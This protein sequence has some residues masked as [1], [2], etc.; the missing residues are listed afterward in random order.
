MLNDKMPNYCH[1]TLVQSMDELF[2][3]SYMYQSCHR[4]SERLVEH[5]RTDVFY[6]KPETVHPSEG[7][8][9]WLLLKVKK[10]KEEETLPSS[11]E[12]SNYLLASQ[13]VDMSQ[14]A[15]KYQSSSVSLGSL[16]TL[17]QVQWNL[18]KNTDYSKTSS[19]V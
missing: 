7:K 14:S 11:T 10:K 8:P 18:G 19:E 6:C 4:A 16:D 17:K 15:K 3:Q 5:M 13:D 2:P 1:W 9:K 12:N